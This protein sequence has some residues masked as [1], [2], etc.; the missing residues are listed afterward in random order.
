MLG[1]QLVGDQGVTGGKGVAGVHT[2]R[3]G[4]VPTWETKEPSGQSEDRAGHGVCSARPGTSLHRP[5]AVA[6]RLCLWRGVLCMESGVWVRT[7]TCEPASWRAA[8][9]CDDEDAL[10]G[11]MC[12]LRHVMGC[13]GQ[14]QESASASDPGLG[15]TCHLPRVT[16]QK[17]QCA[18]IT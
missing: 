10:G 3:P 9:H 6:R 15:W 5:W 1:H 12:D 4:Q 17:G 16:S 13:R 14:C 8:C 2:A 7:P 18:K 11:S